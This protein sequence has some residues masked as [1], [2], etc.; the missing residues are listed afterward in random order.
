[1]TSSPQIHKLQQ[2]SDTKNTARASLAHF[3]DACLQ[4]LTTTASRFTSCSNTVTRARWLRV[5]MLD[6]WRSHRIHRGW[7]AGGAIATAVGP[8]SRAPWSPPVSNHVFS[9][10]SESA[11]TQPICAVNA[12]CGP[13]AKPE[14]PSAPQRHLLHDASKDKGPWL[15][16][17]LE[18]ARGIDGL[19]LLPK[20][21][22]TDSSD[23]QNTTT[24]TLPRFTSCSNTVT[25]KTLHE[26]HLLTSLMLASN[27]SK[28]NIFLAILFG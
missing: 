10:H 23:Q 24:H 27:T 11:P 14:K 12:A 18:A 4:H 20:C 3:L 7:T 1:M 9:P 26:P 17:S 16:I 8:L 28:D 21:L 6:H 5:A 2:H 19:W 25:P 22:Q 15:T 13:R